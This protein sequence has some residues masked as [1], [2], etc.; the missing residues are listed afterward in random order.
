MK[1]VSV[2]ISF[3]HKLL[4][5]AEKALSFVKVEENGL[6]IGDEHIS[7]FDV[8]NRDPSVVDL[9]K[10]SSEGVHK[11]LVHDGTQSFD[12]QLSLR[13]RGA[14]ITPVPSS[15]IFDGCLILQAYWSPQLAHQIP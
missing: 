14:I 7:V 3:D 15:R 2:R 4:A 10:K 11:G 1:L 12:H 9:L 8:L 13:G 5:L 6:T